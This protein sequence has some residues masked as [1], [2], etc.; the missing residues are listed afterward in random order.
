MFTLRETCLPC[1]SSK[2]SFHIWIF[3]NWIYTLHNN[4]HML[5]HL[6][7][8]QWV[9]TWTNCACHIIYLTKQCLY[10]EFTPCWANITLKKYLLDLVFK[11]GFENSTSF[12]VFKK[13]PISNIQK[14]YQIHFKNIWP[15]FENIEYIIKQYLSNIQVSV[16]NPH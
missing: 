5:I 2:I 14:G 1:N 10:V 4:V 12:L 3:K 11:I 7:F 15:V 8:M 9:H 13:K 16:H 6:I